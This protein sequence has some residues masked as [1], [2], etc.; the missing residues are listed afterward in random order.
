[1]SESESIYGTT[2]S[3]ESI[4]VIAESIGVGN[5]P[6]EAA[7]DLAEDVSYRLKEIIQ[8]AT[9][10]MRHGKRQRMTTHD[11]DHALKIKNIEP[12]YGFFA[13]DHIPFR[14]ASGGGRELH[15]V[16]EKE[17]DLNEVVSM[18][19]GQ[20]WPKLPLEITLRAHWLCIDG[21]Q[22]TIP[23]NPPPVSKDVQKLESVDPTTKL[24]S[25]NQNIGIG[26]PGGGGKSQKLRNVE[27]IHVK[28]LATHELSVEQ[29]LYY[30]EITEACVGSDEARRAEAL[31]SL[32]ADP[33]LHEM[34]ARMCTF[35]AEGVR[36]NVV[37]NH[38]ALLIYLMRM[39][40]ALLDNPSLYL[41]KYLHELIPSVATCIVSRQLCMRPEVDNHWALRDFASRLMAQICKNFNTST[42]NV[43]TRVT[44]MFS[45]ALAKNSQTP[46]AS[47]YGAIEGLC[48]LGPEVIKALVI[49]KIKSISDRIES[50]I[51]G[52][53]LDKNGAGHIKTLLVKSVAPV[54]KTIRSPPDYV[55][56][57][58]QD[59]GYIGPALCAAVAKARTQPIALAT[60]TTTTTTALTTN[61]QVHSNCTGKTLVQTV[62]SSSPGQQPGR[63]IMLGTSR[64]ASGTPAPGQKFV[65]L[66]SRSQTPTASNMNTSAIQQQQSQGQQ[67]QQQQPPQQQQQPSPQ[68]VKLAQTNVGQQKAHVP[69]STT[70]VVVVCMAASNHTNTSVT[71]QA[72]LTATTQNVFVT[73]QNVEGSLSPEEEH[74][75]Q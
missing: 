48:E 9:K 28:Q 38:L 1:M 13:K 57:Y 59:Y 65:I 22:P 5:F 71:Q 3:Q 64:N 17:I 33:G 24:S 34:L 20:T 68:Q 36:V 75:F 16:E 45:Q 47:L 55:D 19:G 18:A 14:F 54:L 29:Q 8:D 12:T 66:Q 11:I 61:Q 62:T 53:G 4:K 70:K 32:S 52:Q 49:P 46:L 63:A 51:E 21:V 6:D 30:K 56:S 10:F 40:K 42:N 37:Q 58:K 44:R 31:Q 26:K 27:T 2:L 72:N 73:Q 23:E 67:Q 7:K 41:E 43:Q 35:I 50:C 74:S 25:K 39:V 69:T 60:T 15:F